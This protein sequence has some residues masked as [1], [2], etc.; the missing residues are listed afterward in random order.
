EKVIHGFYMACM[1]FNPYYLMCPEIELNH[2]YCDIFLMPDRR[3]DDIQHSY[4]VEFKYV[5]ANS[6]D[7]EISNKLAEAT[8][9]LTTYAS[10]AKVQN[11][12]DGT[13]LHKIVMIFKGLDVAKCEEV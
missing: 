6:T 4:I 9:Q 13:T 8:S 12:T 7:K 10:D 3:F 1:S 11:M 2:G 5:P